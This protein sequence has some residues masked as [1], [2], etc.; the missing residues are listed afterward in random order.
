MRSMKPTDEIVLAELRK[1]VWADLD[2]TTF[3]LVCKAVEEAGDIRNTSGYAMTLI[4]KAVVEK[5]R[6]SSRSEAG[7][8]AANVRWQSQGGAKK[9]PKAS[10]RYKNMSNAELRNARLKAERAQMLAADNGQGKDVELQQRILDRL[11]AE[12]A[13]RDSMIPRDEQE[14]IDD[15]DLEQR[16]FYAEKIKTGKPSAIANVIYDDI[17]RQGKKVPNNLEPYLDAM[18]TLG[19][20]NQSYGMDSG[21]SIIAYALSNMSTYKGETAKAVKV[22]LRELLKD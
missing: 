18:S 21:R 3:D 8:Y 11:D 12:I 15:K 4:E 16:K 22:K 1:T 6:F 10:D 7:R 19:S 17:R 14:Q 5:A 20:V 9:A 13:Q 2:E